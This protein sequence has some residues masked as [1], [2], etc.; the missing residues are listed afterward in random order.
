[1]TD[2]LDGIAQLFA[3]E[4]AELGLAG[5]SIRSTMDGSV[6]LVGMQLPTNLVASMLRQ[7]ADGYER[8]VGETPLN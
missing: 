4:C 7:A 6:R 2:R 3:E 1:M 5:F 8:Q